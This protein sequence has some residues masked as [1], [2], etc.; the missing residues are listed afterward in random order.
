MTTTDELV[1]N[2]INL[3]FCIRDTT[4]ICIEGTKINLDHYQQRG[5]FLD[6]LLRD[7]VIKE[8]LGQ[9]NA[10]LYDNLLDFYNKCYL[11]TRF[12]TKN[13]NGNY[14]VWKNERAENLSRIGVIFDAINDLEKMIRSSHKLDQ[15]LYELIDIS[16]DYFTVIALLVSLN[17]MKKTFSKTKEDQKYKLERRENFANAM[18]EIQRYISLFLF[19]KQSYNL[20]NKVVLVQLDKINVIIEDFLDNECKTLSAKFLSESIK[21]NSNLVA[22]SRVLN[23]NQTQK[24]KKI[25]LKLSNLKKENSL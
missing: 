7:A 3:S 24:I 23:E 22:Y 11:D 17:E 1:Y 18:V 4:E 9:N 2:L 15:D 12:L 25:E 10:E 14:Y 13:I 16:Q 19:I 8:Y 6:S 21:I 20:N 5:K